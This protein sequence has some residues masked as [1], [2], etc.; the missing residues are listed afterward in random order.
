MRFENDRNQ[1]K[2]GPNRRR[3]ENCPNMQQMDPRKLDKPRLLGTV[4]FQN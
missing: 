3:Q 2:D 4:I 1:K